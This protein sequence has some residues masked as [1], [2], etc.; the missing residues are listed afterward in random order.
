[1]QKLRATTSVSVVRQYECLSNT[2]CG[3]MVE[4]ARAC[5]LCGG[6]PTVVAVMRGSADCAPDRRGPAIRPGR[7]AQCGWANPQHMFYTELNRLGF[8]EGKNL[9]VER[10][11]G[12]GRAHGYAD[13]ARD[14][15]TLV[16]W[17]RLPID[18]GDTGICRSPNN[19]PIWSRRCGATMPTMGYRQ[20]STVRLVRPQ[21]RKDLAEVLARRGSRFPWNRFNDL[22][23]RHPLPAARIIHRYSSL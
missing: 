16:R 1:M 6:S 14:T 10:Y 18:A 12:E 19:T 21:G 7:H 20:L 4:A 23:K 22:L 8:T 13:L 2:G 11:C 3:G 9:L 15:V 5:G 17:R